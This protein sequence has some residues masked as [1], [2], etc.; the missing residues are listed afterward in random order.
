[1]KPTTNA[2]VR[3]AMHLG[4]KITK[5]CVM[6]SLSHWLY[7]KKPIIQSST[8]RYIQYSI[9]K[10]KYSCIWWN[11]ERAEPQ[12]PL[13]SHVFHW[14]YHHAVIRKIPKALPACRRAPS[15]PMR[16]VYLAY[17]WCE[18][19]MPSS[20]NG[21]LSATLFSSPWMDASI[22]D[23]V[24]QLCMGAEYLRLTRSYNISVR[25]KKRQSPK[26]YHV[27]LPRCH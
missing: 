11:I 24:V 7:L 16:F 17:S 2:S 12:S 27:R 23:H 1:M 25:R 15:L 18:R 10:K 5:L 3:C 14:A 20:A 4:N 19:V 8:P 13:S 22:V 6:F 26:Y 21:T 9:L